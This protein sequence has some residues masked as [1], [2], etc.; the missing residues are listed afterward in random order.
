MRQG[1]RVLD[2]QPLL[3][4][5]CRPARGEISVECFAVVA[6]GSEADYCPRNVRPA[7]RAARGLRQYGLVSHGDAKLV[8]QADDALSSQLAGAPEHRQT[9]LDGVGAG[10]VQRQDV[11]LVR[12][13]VRT[14]LDSPNHAKSNFISGGDRLGDARHRIVVGES[15]R[16]EP[17]GVSRGDDIARTK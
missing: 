14:E 5:I 2:L 9:R 17:G 16:I 8:Q 12:A 11:N 1:D 6:G 4:D 13:V 10:D 3:G 15:D 7:Y